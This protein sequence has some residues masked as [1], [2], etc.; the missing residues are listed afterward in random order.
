MKTPQA[1]LLIL[2]AVL[3]PP[4]AL[5]ALGEVIDEQTVQT[6]YGPFGPLA[7]RAVPDAA[8]VWVAPYTGSPTRNDPRAAIHTMT[9]LNARRLLIWDTAI[10]LNPVLPRGITAIVDDYIDWT[11]HLPSTFGGTGDPA[12]ESVPAPDAELSRQPRGQIF[13]PEM[14]QS[15]HVAFPHSPAVTYIGVDDLRRETP[16]E[17]RMFRLWGGDVIGRNLVPEVALARE[18]GHCVAGLVTVDDFDAGRPAPPTRGEVRA[19]LEHG[20]YALNEFAREAGRAI[21]CTCSAHIQ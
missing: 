13:C 21:H 3:L 19:A 15:L 11:R 2:I 9:S 5:D 8:P 7:L 12:A 16:A 10:A 14:A 4:F 18:L 1:S 17:A 20:I 6:P